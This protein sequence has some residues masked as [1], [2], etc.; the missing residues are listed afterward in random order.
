MIRILKK[1]GILLF[2]FLLGVIGTA[3]LLNSES[4]DN[5]SDFNDATFPEVMIDMDGTLMNRSI[6]EEEQVSLTENLLTAGS[7]FKRKGAWV[8][9]EE[10][11]VD[12]MRK[13]VKDMGL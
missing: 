2:V 11:A 1:T 4:T 13:A 10:L 9:A 8:T 6:F 12:G 3:L 5:R 7:F